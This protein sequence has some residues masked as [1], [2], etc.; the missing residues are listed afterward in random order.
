MIKKN[1]HVVLL[2]DDGPL[3]GTVIG[4]T[5]DVLLV[6]SPISEDFGIPTRKI[7]PKTLNCVSITTVSFS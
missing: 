3:F 5:T 2:V 7:Q 6:V 1:L 4:F